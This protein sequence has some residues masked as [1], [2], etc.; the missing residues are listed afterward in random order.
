V[1]TLRRSNPAAPAQGYALRPT[2]PDALS[3]VSTE[4]LLLVLRRRVIAPRNRRRNTWDGR[5]DPHGHWPE[6]GWQHRRYLAARSG[7]ADPNDKE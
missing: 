6:Q 7:Q 5:L 2:N 1:P 3:Q 4:K